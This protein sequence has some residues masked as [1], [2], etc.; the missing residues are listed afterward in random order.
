VCSTVTVKNVGDLDLHVA[1]VIACDSLGFY[2][3][4]AGLLS[5]IAPGDSSAFLACFTPKFSGAET[6]SV[7][8]VTDGGTGTAVVIVDN[9]TAVTE[10]R[11]LSSRLRLSVRPNPF[12]ASSRIRFDLPAPAPVRV[13][14]FDLRGRRVRTVVSGEVRPAGEYEVVWDGRTDLGT[15]TGAGVYF[16]KLAAGEATR[17]TR[18]VK[19]R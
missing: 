17:V 8:V 13:E 1:S 11:V 18:A 5:T 7:A 16:I 3:D 15:A 9:T 10:D 2:V 6:C 19:L 4:T 12:G 14:V